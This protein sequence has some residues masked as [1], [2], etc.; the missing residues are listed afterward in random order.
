L[1]VMNTELAKTGWRE[2][3]VGT[4]LCVEPVREDRAP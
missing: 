4:S 1:A 2:K 3:V